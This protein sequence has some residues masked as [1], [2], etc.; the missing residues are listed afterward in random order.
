[1]K[2]VT[3]NPK[4]ALIQFATF[5]TFSLVQGPWRGCTQYTY[6]SLERELLCESEFSCELQE[7][8]TPCN[9]SIGQSAASWA[10][11]DWRDL[12]DL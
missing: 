1:M 11:L 5:I 4:K 9:M 2:S 10:G 12:H 7:P 8:R 3:V 6:T